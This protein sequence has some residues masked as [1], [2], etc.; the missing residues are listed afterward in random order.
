MPNAMRT[1]QGEVPLYDKLSPFLDDAQNWL[2]AYFVPEPLMAEIEQVPHI[3]ACEAF[4]VALPRLDVVLTPNGLATAG[5]DRLVAASA[6]RTDRLLAS[7][8]VERDLLLDMMLQQLPAKEGWVDTP[9]GKYFSGT[10][11]PTLGVVRRTGSKE[12]LWNGYIALRDRIA[13]IEDSMAADWLS[14]QLM[15]YLRKGNCTGTLSAKES[16]IVDAVCA[17]VVRVAQGGRLSLARMAD[18][19]EFIR[20]C[21]DDFPLWHS[22]PT[23]ELFSP[24]VFRNKKSSSGYFF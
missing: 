8:M 2:E 16:F 4:R 5:S 24:P 15:H 23:A 22:S 1:V 10:L 11:F 6:Q 12:P 13:G 3:V 17:E 7:L 18:I 9:Q 14:P 21:P 19:V 20:S